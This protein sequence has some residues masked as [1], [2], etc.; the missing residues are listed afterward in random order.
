MIE[1]VEYLIKFKDL[2]YLHAEW[3][4][5]YRLQCDPNASRKLHS[6]L[7]KH[8][9]EAGIRHPS[10]AHDSEEDASDWDGY[11]PD[12]RRVERFVAVST[13]KGVVGGSGSSVANSG[14][15]PTLDSKLATALS[16]V[17]SGELR[18]RIAFLEERNAKDGLMIKGREML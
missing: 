5:E 15:F 11:N 13:G 1:V 4:S 12:F 18:G 16:K 7:R 6:W 10:E 8:E 14:P 17:I 3:V 9:L 2:S